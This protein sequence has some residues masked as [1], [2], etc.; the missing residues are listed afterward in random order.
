M[1]SE[2][3]PTMS[4]FVVDAYEDVAFEQEKNFL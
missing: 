1:A 2:Y 4:F 3:I